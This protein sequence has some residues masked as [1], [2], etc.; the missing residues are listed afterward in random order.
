MPAHLA[1]RR[2]RGFPISVFERMSIKN[3]YF[4]NSWLMGALSLSNKQM[5]Y[6]IS[7]LSARNPV[8]L[9][10]LDCWARIHIHNENI[11]NIQSEIKENIVIRAE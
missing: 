4:M 7:N 1:N 2:K 11:D 6:M 10:L 9:Y 8:R 3:T 5:N